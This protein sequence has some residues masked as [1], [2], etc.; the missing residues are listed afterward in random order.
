MLL[1]YFRGSRNKTFEAIA[2]FDEPKVVVM[3]VMSAKS[4]AS[5]ES[6]QP[7]FR[8]LLESY[9]FVGE[10]VQSPEPDKKQSP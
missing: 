1:R 7:A 6:A 5:F 2:Y 8:T 4:K 3:L 10:F 9:K